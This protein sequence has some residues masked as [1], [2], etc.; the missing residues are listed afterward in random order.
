MLL[1]A[2]LLVSIPAALAAQRVLVLGDSLSDAY[3]MPREAGWV[4]LLDQRL[5]PDVEVI[6]GA[7][8][9]DTSAGALARL[10]P[11]LADARPDAMIIILGG[12]DGLRGLDPS[13]LER[14][15]D[16]IISRTLE[17]G[18]ACA[19]MQIRL[20]PNLG[21][22]YVEAFEAVYPR[23][24]SAHRIALLDFFLEPL[25]GQPG[26]LMDDGIHPTA[27]AQ[28][29]LAEAM[30]EPVRMLLDRARDDGSD[31]AQLEGL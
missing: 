25:I 20:P 12:N 10:D 11:L 4:H 18:V 29:L 2:G 31:H 13:M 6:D 26:M 7:I 14:T 19:L 21:P 17:R 24:A 8:S 30:V 23:L 22:R 3:G 16:Q 28:P 9:G 27:A 5:G 1:A 15:L